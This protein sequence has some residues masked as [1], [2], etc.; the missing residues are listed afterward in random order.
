VIRLRV[1]A[2][3]A[4]AALLLLSALPPAPAAAETTLTIG[5][6]QLKKDRTYG[7]SRTFAQYLMQPLGRPWAGSQVALDEIRWHGAAAGVSFALARER[8]AD[9]DGVADAIRSMAAEKGVRFFVL[10]LPAD[11][12]AATAA[13]LK[14]EPL[15]LFN[16]SARDDALR[17][18]AC[19]PNLLHTMPSHA[20]LADALGQY[21]VFR[22]WT[23]ALL[24]TGPRAA[25][26]A[27]ADA[28]RRTAR[29]YG[30][31]IDADRPFVLSNDPRIREE[32]NPILLTS[33]ADYDVVVVMDTDGEFARNLMY[34]TQHPRPVVGADGLA[35]LAW[36]WAWERHGA[37][38]LEKRFQDM[39]ERPMRG[40]DWAAWMAVKTVAEAVQRTDSAEFE[41][42]KAYITGPDLVLDGFK[43]NRLNFRPWNGQLRQP[44]LLGTHNW[45]VA[46]APLDGFLHRVNTLD[47]LGDDE[48]DSRCER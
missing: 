6:V 20:M 47:T 37:P 13:A 39:A 30:I 34:R 42:L 4:F 43:G 9:R 7:R 31:E 11:V 3:L 2:A 48:R 45:V 18:A 24:L 32:N 16:A 5:H 41:T 29:R 8:V 44:V 10:D 26:R 28:F 38:Q 25:D 14:D 40:V 46:R 19:Q 17:G 15:L 23:E 1:P 12:M 35:P 36:H 27:W 33:G 22:K 21:L